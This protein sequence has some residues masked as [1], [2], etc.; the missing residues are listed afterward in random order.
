[1]EVFLWKKFNAMKEQE[2]VIE[3]LRAW[4]EIK[5][6]KLICEN[7]CPKWCLFFLNHVFRSLGSSFKPKR[8][9]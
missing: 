9:K 1:M 7:E 5:I 2:F 6:P 3:I 8:Q 4:I